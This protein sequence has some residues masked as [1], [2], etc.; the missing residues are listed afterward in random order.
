LTDVL[1]AGS[2]GLVL[3][4]PMLMI[5]LCVALTMGHPV[6]FTQLRCGMGGRPFRLIKFRSMTDACNSCGEL[7]DDAARTTP[8]GRLLRRT[9]LDELP[10][11]WNVLRGDMSLIGPRPLLPATVE[12]MGEAGL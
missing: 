7:L 3:L 2:A 6:L 10:E 1:L 9:R 5:G 4:V 11:L 8:F 12:T